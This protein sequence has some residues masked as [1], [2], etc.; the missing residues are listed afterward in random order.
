MQNKLKLLALLFITGLISAFAQRRLPDIK[1]N[2]PLDSIRMSDPFILADKKTNM[3][4]MTGTGGLLWKSKDLKYWDGPFAVAKPDPKSWMGKNP[5]IWA[6]EIH[7]YN[8]KYYYFAT[9]T[10]KK[11]TI[12]DKKNVRRSSHIL[13]SKTPDGPF[14]PM[15]EKTYLPAALSTLDAT[16]WVDHDKNA[17]MVYCHEWLQNNDGTVEKIALKPDFSGTLGNAKILFRATDSPWNR[18]RE[19]NEATPH[20]VTDGPWLFRTQT[21]KLGMLW[22][23]WVYDVYTQGVAYS[24][25]GTLDGPWIQDTEP[26]TP[27]NYGHC[28]TFRTFEGKL[29]LC[30]HTH[31]ADKNG[32]FIRTPKLFEVDDS[33]D[34]LT[35]GKPFFPIPMV[36]SEK[37]MAAYLMVYFKDDTHSLHFA[38][39]K[40]GYSFTD[41]NK[42]NPIILGDSIA[43]QKG[44]RDPY[45]MRGNDG[46]F[47][48]AMT[49]L[50]VFGIRDGL[51][52]TQWERDGKEFGWGNNRNIVLMKSKD[53]IKWTHTLLRV[54]KAFPGWEK[55][56]CAWAPELIY[57]PLQEKIMIYFTMR[58]GNGVNQM[59]YT[60]M[61]HDFT[62]METEPRLLFQYPKINKNTIDGDITKVN[63][64][65]HLFYVAHDGGAGVKQ[66][67]SK[68][69]N[70]GYTYEDKWC[71]PEPKAC[72]APNVWKRIGEEKW[73][74]MYDIFGVTPHNFGF[75]E[76]TDFI[77]F[78]DLG[79]FNEGIMKATN[80]S[81]PKHGAVIQLT[82]D[83]AK[84]LAKQWTLDMIF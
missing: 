67:V 28:M 18:A 10:N 56:G 22:T 54:D 68:N 27:S 23:S 66:E 4:Y 32:R 75:S 33:G 73:I 74:L 41:I 45:I 84:K 21:G 9:F 39:S 12:D 42:G 83:E 64:S 50:H 19:G 52:D 71:D 3:Y 57:D 5:E 43:E 37:D 69:I 49:D 20:K 51:R 60:Y 13:I 44:I 35:V 29:L 62:A 72:E 24:E 58:F 48:M 63:D 31:S 79:H 47:Y 78:T 1:H 76:T 15:E 11:I 7:E 77:H 14:V 26:I 30:G 46:Y 8:N 25:S 61:N 55:L 16:L 17:Y 2:I 70:F 36:T 40:D 53:L 34:K 82:K 6:A 80:F 65:Y 38:L 59:V 81:S